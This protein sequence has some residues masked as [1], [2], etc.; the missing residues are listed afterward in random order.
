MHYFFRV[1]MNAFSLDDRWLVIGVEV[2][3]ELPEARFVTG[4]ST[5]DFLKKITEGQFYKVL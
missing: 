3:G 5:H 1:L 2:T 4:N